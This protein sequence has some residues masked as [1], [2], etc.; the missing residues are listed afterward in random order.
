MLWAP[1]G[2]PEKIVTCFLGFLALYI[3]FR[4]CKQHIITILSHQSWSPIDFKK[5]P[6]L[7]AEPP[8]KN[9]GRFAADFLQKKTPT[10]QKK[11][12]LR[13]ES[14]QKKTSICFFLAE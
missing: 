9:V 4:A 10:C 13:A 1:I 7:R 2:A 8:K 5:N 11:T 12:A 6:A 14:C 3:D